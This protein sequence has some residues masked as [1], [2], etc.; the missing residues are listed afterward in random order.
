MW[1]CAVATGAG[2]FHLTIACTR[3]S[4]SVMSFAKRK[5]AKATPLMESGEAGVIIQTSLVYMF[6]KYVW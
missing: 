3:T 2:N 1:S 4:I 5:T 6:K